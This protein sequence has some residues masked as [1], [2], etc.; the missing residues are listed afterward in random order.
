MQSNKGPGE[1][2]MRV[3]STKLV[4]VAL[5]VALMS[6]CATMKQDIEQAKQT[7]QQAANDAAAAKRAADGAA[8]AANEAKTL[9]TN[10]Q[11]TAEAAKRAADQANAC[12]AANT[13][14]ID[15]AF[16]TGQRK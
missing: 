2:R 9:A 4:A 11:S 16:R 12:C 8:A 15:R 5:S 3:T 7:A 6:G 1:I 13:E 10:A 14:K